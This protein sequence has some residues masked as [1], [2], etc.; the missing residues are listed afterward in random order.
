MTRR[1]WTTLGIL[2]VSASLPAIAAAE[3]AAEQAEMAA[4]KAVTVEP[5][6]VV[7]PLYTMKN[8][9]DI[10]LL[11][12]SSVSDHMVAHIGGALTADYHLN[13][14]LSIGLFAAAGDSR[15]N[16]LAQTI[17]S[18]TSA[19]GGDDLAGAGRP[20]WTGQL[21]ARFTPL[22]GKFNLASEYSMHFHFYVMGGIGAAQVKSMSILTQNDDRRPEVGLAGN[23][24]LGL[25]LWMNRTLSLRVEAR[26]LLFGE[27]YYRG[28]ETYS[29]GPG[30]ATL[31]GSLG[32]MTL[33]YAGLGVTL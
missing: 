19:T 5:P 27:S 30:S 32:Q 12:G 20:T 6:T 1:S 23:I 2:A 26:Q 4:E 22:Y 24:G 17:T 15:L 10:G 28:V 31:T 7:R 33:I 29:N 3:T 25:R 21:G 16:T 11:G 18:E 13:E 14:F 9:I 8:R